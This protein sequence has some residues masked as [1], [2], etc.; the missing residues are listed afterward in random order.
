MLDTMR[1]NGVNPY[2]HKFNRDMT[3]QQFR[4]RFED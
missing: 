3:V 1:E 2:P 4:D